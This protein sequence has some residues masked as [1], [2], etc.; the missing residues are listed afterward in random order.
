VPFE[1][2]QQH[3]HEQR[4]EKDPA[5][6]ERVGKVHRGLGAILSKDIRMPD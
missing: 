1:L 4:Y 6:R 5:D 2:R 3:D